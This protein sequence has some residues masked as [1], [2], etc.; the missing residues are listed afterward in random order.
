[1]E[2]ASNA[3]KLDRGVVHRIADVA[4]GMVFLHWVSTSRF[5]LLAPEMTG[6]TI[7]QQFNIICPEN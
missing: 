6:R 4:L 7:Y 2:I 5:L 1:M 3:R